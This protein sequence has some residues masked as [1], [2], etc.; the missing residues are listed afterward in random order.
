[1]SVINNKPTSTWYRLAGTLIS[2]M[3]TTSD[4][5]HFNFRMLAQSRDLMVT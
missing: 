5:N 1:M 4:N 3:V 2:E